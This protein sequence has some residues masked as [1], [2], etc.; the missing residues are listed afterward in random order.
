MTIIV[1]EFPTYP[2]TI[3]RPPEPPD[4]R[5]LMLENRPDPAAGAARGFLRTLE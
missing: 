3:A 5:T 4:P 2:V 1:E